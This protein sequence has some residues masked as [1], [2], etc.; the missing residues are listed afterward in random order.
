MRQK[1]MPATRNNQYLGFSVPHNIVDQGSWAKHATYD[2][3]DEPRAYANRLL[4]GAVLD[5][6]PRK[7]RDE[8]NWIGGKQYLDPK[9]GLLTWCHA[10]APRTRSAM[11]RTKMFII[12]GMVG[13]NVDAVVRGAKVQR[14]RRGKGTP[15]N[16]FWVPLEK[17]SGE[18]MYDAL[19]GADVL[20]EEFLRW[21]DTREVL[22]IPTLEELE[23]SMGRMSVSPTPTR[24]E[25][26]EEVEN[27]VEWDK[28]YDKEEMEKALNEA[29]VTSLFT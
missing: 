18:D 21:L 22:P 16:P 3:L 1:T 27:F 17:V 13:S 10:G 26:L 24:V 9:R 7:E 5:Y 14:N 8:R 20:K 29:H 11:K 19:L 25:G 6:I 23:K 28:V 15:Y 4:P 12:E 2:S